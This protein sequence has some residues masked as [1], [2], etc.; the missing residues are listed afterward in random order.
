MFSKTY[1]TD[2]TLFDNIIMSNNVTAVT[3]RYFI[4]LDTQ[5]YVTLQRPFG[6][7]KTIFTYQYQN[8]YQNLKLNKNL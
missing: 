6:K 5:K 7:S 8:Q 2:V 1:F 4:F 3:E